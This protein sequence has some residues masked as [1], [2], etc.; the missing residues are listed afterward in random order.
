VTGGLT[1][2]AGPTAVGK[3]TLV[4]LLAE[5]FPQV[6][7]SVSA[8]TRA[9]RPGET[10]GVHYLFLTDQEFD[11]LIANNGLL[12]W[13]TVHGTE[14]YGTP[15]APALAAV[16]AGR[17]VILEIDVQGARQVRE[18]IPG[19]RMVFIAPPSWEE[20]RSRLEGRGTETDAQM[21][22]RLRTAQEEMEAAG[23][24]DA[25]VVNDQL[26]EAVQELVRLLG[27]EPESDDRR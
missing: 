7:V 25:V 17:H 21:A 22:R 15:A 4:S 18:R 19:A 26:G 20:L 27:L 10:E 16:E 14:R 9:P 23:E 13:A 11:D 3:G 1:V 5:R 12:E 8:T 2:I 6:W 24:F